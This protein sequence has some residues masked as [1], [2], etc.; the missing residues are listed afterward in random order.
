ME[1]KD[2]YQVF[3]GG[4]HT[5]ITISTTV[6]NEKNLLVFK[7][8]FA[9]CFIQFL[10]PYYQTITIIDP[11]YYYDSVD[12]LIENSSITNV[13]FLYNA[14]TFVRDNSLADVIAPSVS[15]GAAAE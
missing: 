12:T 14:N 4:N 10:L 3:F 2:K 9:N 11:R 1:N 7:D 13:L 15:D 5:R 6:A 8:S